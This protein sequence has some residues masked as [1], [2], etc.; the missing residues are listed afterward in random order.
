MW[1]IPKIFPP[2]LLELTLVVSN[3]VSLLFFIFF[4]SFK[5]GLFVVLKEKLV[6]V[7]G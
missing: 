3:G 6:G 7:G 1:N 4:P 2:V 5:I